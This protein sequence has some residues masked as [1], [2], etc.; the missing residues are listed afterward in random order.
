MATSKIVKTRKFS[1]TLWSGNITL[2]K[3]DQTI[4]LLE[5]R[6][7]GQYYIFLFTKD[8]YYKMVALVSRYDG[9][10]GHTYVGNDEII[11]AYTDKNHVIIRLGSNV[12]SAYV[13][14]TIIA[15]SH[16]GF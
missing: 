5:R 10:N 7:Q 8:T 11:L 16:E 4:D 6:D 12:T 15:V 13:L 2:T 9:Y 1:K 3:Q 14:N